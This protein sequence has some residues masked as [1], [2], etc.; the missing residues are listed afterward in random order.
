M[1]WFSAIFAFEEW[2]MWPLAVDAAS[3]W[4]ER[5]RFRSRSS[6]L[7]PTLYSG[8]RSRPPQTS[9]YVCLVKVSLEVQELDYLWQNSSPDRFSDIL[10]ISSRFLIDSIQLQWR[11]RNVVKFRKWGKRDQVAG[12]F[13]DRWQFV[14]AIFLHRGRFEERGRKH[15]G[16][17]ELWSCFAHGWILSQ[18]SMLWLQ[19]EGSLQRNGESHL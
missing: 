3:N 17:F 14:F 7:I 19:Q 9:A 1:D 5:Q 2:P 4:G 13:L 8:T 16:K 12:P 6:H 11:S 15:V 18:H 10:D